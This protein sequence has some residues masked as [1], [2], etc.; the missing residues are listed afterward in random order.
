M[1]S[2]RMGLLALLVAVSLAGC[3]TDKWRALPEKNVHIDAGFVHY[4]NWLTP[5]T[6]ICSPF[7]GACNGNPW[8]YTVPGM[9][10]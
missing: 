9:G 7:D 8:G 3:S 10:D 2:I 1:K 5:T 6:V 4:D